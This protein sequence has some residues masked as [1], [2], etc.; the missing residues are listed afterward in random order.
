MIGIIAALAEETELLLEAAENKHHHHYGPF[1]FVT[2]TLE[3]KECVI[4]VCGVGKVMAAMCAAVMLLQFK[5]EALIN[6]GAAGGLKKGMKIG[7]MVFST[8]AAYHDFDATVFGYKLGQTPGHDPVFT[9]DAALRQK[10]RQA[11]DKLQ[12]QKGRHILEGLVLSGDQFVSS[13]EKVDFL[14]RTFPEA[15]CV[16]MEGAAIANAASDFKVP[17]LIIRAVSDSA[18]DHGAMSYDEFSRKASHE[19]ARLVRALLQ[20]L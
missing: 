7:D 6:T 3:G 4:C 10:A 5:P 2:C 1:E 18:D 8:G 20:E 13:G 15:V 12:L 19:S 17:F 11:A 14:T 16:E 9:A